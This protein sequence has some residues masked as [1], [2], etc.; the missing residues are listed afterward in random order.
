MKNLLLTWEPYGENEEVFCSPFHCQETKNGEIFG[1]WFQQ[2]TRIIAVSDSVKKKK[3]VKNWEELVEKEEDLLKAFIF[4][5]M[6]LVFEK[7]IKW[8]CVIMHFLV[9]KY[10]L[11]QIYANEAFLTCDRYNLSITHLLLHSWGMD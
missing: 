2:E 3:R 8:E 11:L 10:S 4:N 1:E 9:M 7:K 5:V 6:N